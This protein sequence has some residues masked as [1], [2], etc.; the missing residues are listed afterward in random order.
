MTDETD[1]RE[2]ALGVIGAGVVFAV[3]WG[4]LWMS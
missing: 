1:L 4:A 2:I 3:L